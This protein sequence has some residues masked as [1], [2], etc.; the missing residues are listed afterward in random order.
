MILCIFEDTYKYLGGGGLLSPDSDQKIAVGKAKILTFPCPHR[1][2]RYSARG[3]EVQLRSFLTS[4]LDEGDWLT[5]RPGRYARKSIAV[6]D[7]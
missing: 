7:E 1:E 6:P 5:L 2:S 3:V 4:A